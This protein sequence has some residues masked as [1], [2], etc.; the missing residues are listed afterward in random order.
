MSTTT[1]TT[2]TDLDPRAVRALTE[3][4]AVHEDDPDAW[5][6]HEVAV[7]SEDR[8][9]LVNVAIGYCD[10]PSNQ[11]HAGQC[12]HER[13]ARYALG[14]ESVPAWVR[15]DRLDDHLRTRLEDDS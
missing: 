14:I 15:M 2:P 12:K 13:R 10:C 3:P 8:R 7:Y 11:Y 4:M 5:G 9:Y 6:D 1:D